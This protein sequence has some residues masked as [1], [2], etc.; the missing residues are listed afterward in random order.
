MREAYPF[1]LG[2]QGRRREKMKTLV[3]ILSI[4]M[5]LA[6]TVPGFAAGKSNR[7]IL[8]EGLL[9]A[10]TGAI[11]ADQSDGKAG[12]GALIGAGT[13]VVGGAL[14]DVIMPDD[15]AAGAPAAAP[16]P[17]VRGAVPQDLYQ[18]GYQAGYQEGF[19][20]GYAEGLKTRR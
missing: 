6:L 2:R 1:G 5:V 13:N 14:L 9:G 3:F 11:A 18:Q 8:K 7:N 4:C 15:P 16:A 20:A 17:A 19:K 10:A 12:K